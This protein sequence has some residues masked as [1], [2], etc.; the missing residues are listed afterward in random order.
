MSE[1]NLEKLSA[2]HEQE[3]LMGGL[4]DK[5]QY[6]ETIDHQVRI[7]QQE[8]ASTHPVSDINNSSLQIPTLET[9]LGRN[10]EG[11]EGTSSLAN[12]QVKQVPPHLGYNLHR[13]A[14]G[15]GDIILTG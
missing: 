13:F 8:A 11:V 3:R 5:S 12:K 4:K 6:I 1:G 7:K 14:A 2:E 9:L 10:N 15:T